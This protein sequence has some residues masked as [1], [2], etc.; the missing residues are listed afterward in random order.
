MGKRTPV[1]FTLFEDLPAPEPDC[2]EAH[3]W[4]K[5]VTDWG[6][7]WGERLTETCQRCGEVRG[8]CP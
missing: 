3:D 4:R 7:P 5:T 6:E 1:G 8:R 2:S